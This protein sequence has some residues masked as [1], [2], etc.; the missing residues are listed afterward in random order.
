MT[1]L[2][3]RLE[4]VR[5]RMGRACRQAGRDPASVRLLAASKTRSIHEVRQAWAAG[6]RLFG[7]SRAQEL[8]DKAR[9]LAELRELRWHFIG[10]LQRNK[11]KYVVGRVGMVHSVDDEDIARALSERVLAIGAAALPVLVEVNVAAEPTKAG[12]AM[13]DC[14]SFCRGVAALPGLRL[15]G[16]MSI[17]PYSDD[18]EDSAGYHRSL[19][20]LAR[21]GRAQGLGLDELS[22]GMSHDLEPAIRAGAT[23][24]RVGTDIFG[25]R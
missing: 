17:P 6:Q 5:A 3:E 24:V 15:A 23:I 13:A 22:M 16:L 11:V 20:D 4:H 2:A 7:E 12:V 10:P 14:L 21:Q 8:R 19:A 9:A 18:P 25:P 1:T